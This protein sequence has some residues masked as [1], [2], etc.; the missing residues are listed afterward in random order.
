MIYGLIVMLKLQMLKW[1]T[2]CGLFHCLVQN[3]DR[4]L[5][6]LQWVMPCW[7]FSWIQ[8][9]FPASQAEWNSEVLMIFIWPFYNEASCVSARKRSDWMQH[10]NQFHFLIVQQWSAATQWHFCLIINKHLSL[11][12]IQNHTK[13]F[14]WFNH[15]R[16]ISIWAIQ[17][18]TASHY[19]D[20]LCIYPLAR[21][22]VRW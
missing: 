10:N 2:G 18:E 4:S 17:R 12:Q 20:V 21:E 22:R 7:Q 8:R 6:L 14:Y 5:Q 9:L 3:E 13:I 16:F 15:N 11:L 1:S 19:S